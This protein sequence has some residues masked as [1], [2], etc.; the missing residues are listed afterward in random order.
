M[1]IIVIERVIYY[2]SY[3]RW[4]RWWCQNAVAATVRCVAW[5]PS[6]TVPA[7]TAIPRLSPTSDVPPDERALCKC[8]C[9]VDV[10]SASKNTSWLRRNY[11]HDVGAMLL[12][13]WIIY[14]FIYY[15][16]VH[17]VH[18]RQTYIVRKKGTNF[19]FCAFLALTESGG[20]FTYIRTKENRSIS[21]NFVV[22]F[23]CIENFVASVKLNILCLPVK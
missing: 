13:V 21:Y 2:R 6:P 14:L 22:I 7:S 16:I 5:F 19:L 10:V 17:E 9:S 8:K 4:G 1:I 11:R 18:H 20:F 3:H 23:A 15:K 12:A